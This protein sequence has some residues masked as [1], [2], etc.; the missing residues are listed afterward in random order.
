MA[1]IIG[2]P[3]T[4]KVSFSLSPVYNVIVSLAL[5]GMAQDFTGLNEWVYQSVKTLSPEQLRTNE[6]VLQDAYVHLAG[7]AWPSFP[8][9]V[10]DLA[11]RDAIAMRD[12]AFQVWLADVSRA[13][14]EI[15]DPS[16]LLA[17]RAVYLALVEDFLRS[18]DYDRSLW[19]DMHA[20]LNDP[21]AM[22]DLIVT[23]LRTM[24]EVVAPEWERNLPLLEESI[25]AFQSLDFEGLTAVQALQRVILRELPS[26][27]GVER[28]A[29]VEHFVFIP[30]A[31]NGP[32]VLLLN[33]LDDDVVYMTF[34]ARIPQ[35]VPARGSALSRSELLMRL[36][37]LSDDTRLRIVELLAQEGEQSTPDIKTQLEISQ[38][39][40]SRHL[41]HLTATG[42]LLARRQQGVNFY[43]LNPSRIEHTLQALREFCRMT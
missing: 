20:L 39:A 4:V 34:G 42:Y 41:E 27:I 16:E 24:W 7:A 40:A 26:N 28:L 33:S 38:S 2:P 29:D 15:P 1:E 18:R 22:Q 21:A 36:N 19:E 13:V 35:G 12:R 14:G 9:W 5:F 37:A 43:Q 31:H 23:H 10:N 30:S 32:Y 8:A 17:D 6:I 25:A 11:A 3:K